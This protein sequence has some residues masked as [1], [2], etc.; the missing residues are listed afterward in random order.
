MLKLSSKTGIAKAKQ[1]TVFNYMTDFRNFIHLIPANKIDEIEVTEDSIKFSL[2]G[3]GLVGL[4]IAGKEPYNRLIIDALEGTAADFNLRV[5][6]DPETTDT[7]RV[8][9]E[10]DANLNLFIEMMARNPLQQF[11]DLIIDKVETIEYKV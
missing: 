7:S 2:P 5:Q 4:K 9:L 1:E 8:S 11:L 3:L 6:I 10:L